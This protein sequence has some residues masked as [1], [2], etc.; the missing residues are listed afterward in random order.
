MAEYLVEIDGGDDLAQIELEIQFE[1]K[2]PA[3]FIESALSYYK[4]RFTNIAKFR[5]VPFTTS[6]KGVRLTLSSVQA[7][8]GFV[9]YWTGTM[10][11]AKAN[12]LVSAWRQ[13]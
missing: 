1:E 11:I 12:T 8:P 13:S 9:R 6:P 2:S 4:D 3:F 7:V 5:E 10:L